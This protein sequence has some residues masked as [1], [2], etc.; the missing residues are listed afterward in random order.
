[1]V[2]KYHVGKKWVREQKNKWKFDE[3]LSTFPRKLILQ[4]PTPEK[5]QTYSNNSSAKAGELFECV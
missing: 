3:F 4:A 1:M 5:G 2:L